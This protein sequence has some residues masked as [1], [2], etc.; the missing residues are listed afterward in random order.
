MKKWGSLAIFCFV[1]SGAVTLL[2]QENKDTETT[3]SPPKIQERYN[4]EQAELERPA[5]KGLAHEKKIIG[6]VPNGYGQVVT[7]SQREEIYKI[8]KDYNELIEL[9]KVRIHLL[10]VERDNNIDGL[11][12]VEQKQRIKRYNGT[13]ESE[14]YQRQETQNSSRTRRPVP[15]TSAP[16]TP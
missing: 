13:L 10:E 2:A 6:R 12:S 4:L 5:S 8:Q 7:N 3:T 1:I 15:T 9:I 11:L 14:K 16:R